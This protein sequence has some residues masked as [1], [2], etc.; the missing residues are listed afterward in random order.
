MESKV[1]YVEI[2]GSKDTEYVYDIEVKDNHN[3]FAD[4]I[5]IHNCLVLDE[6]HRISD[7]VIREKLVPMLGS[8]SISKTIK[9]G[10]SLYKNNFFHSCNSS[11]SQYKVIRKGWQDC[12]IYWKQGFIRYEG[13]EYP[14]R[15]VDLMPRIVKQ[16]LFPNDLNLHYDSVE[17]YSEVEWNTQ[18]EMIWM[19]DI[20]LAL[21]SEQQK[22][23]VSG[24]F[25]ILEKG[26]PEMTEK[27]YF[28]LDTASGSLMPGKKDLDFTILSIWRK[29]Y[30]NIKQC[31]AQYGWQGDVVQQM[32]EI[33]EIIHPDRG[34]FKCVFGLADYS[35]IA[36][37][38]VEMFKKENIPIAGVTFNATEPTTKKNYKNAMVDQF[39]FELDNGRVQYPTMDKIEND[40]LFRE[41]FSQW[42]LLERHKKTGINDLI[43]VD[44]SMGH[45]D[46]PMSNILG[47]WAADQMTAHSADIPRRMSTIAKP[48][49]GPSNMAGGTIPMPGYQNPTE[50]RFLRDKK[51]V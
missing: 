8:F 18:Y 15:I 27:Y 6:A 49:S 3:F 23:L 46:F 42:C 30:D 32:D 40:K 14:K 26:R 47:V 7:W 16:R 33:K 25:D 34:V 51:G 38:I 21:S 11:S 12:D 50:S 35:N 1:K 10:I 5:L 24:D 19:E 31:V 39:V 20:N 29:T 22:L 13:R 37:G 28:G 44:P 17:G 4:N 9:I 36:I 45:D 43:F 48:V 41:G 2:V